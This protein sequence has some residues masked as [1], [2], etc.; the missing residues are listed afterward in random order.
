VTNFIFA[1]LS[2]E[3]LQSSALDFIN[4][5]I[6]IAL[7]MKKIFTFFALVAVANLSLASHSLAGEVKKQ[8]LQLEEKVEL[9]KQEAQDHPEVQHIAAG[10]TSGYGIIQLAAALGV[11][12]LAYEQLNDD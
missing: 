2:C 4:D 9:T 7:P 10:V 6:I 12:Y 3:Y 1:N 5:T 11:G 8:P